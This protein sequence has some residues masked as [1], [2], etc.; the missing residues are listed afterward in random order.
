MKPASTDEVARV[1]QLLS[2]ER[3]AMVPQGGNTSLC[4]GSVP[5]ASGAQVV[6]N[7]SRMNRVRA[8][9]TDN[10][11]MTVEAGCVLASLQ[12][13]AD[14]HGR[15]FPLSLGAEGSCEIGGN[16]STNA[17][18]TGVLRYGNTRELVLGLEVVLADGQVWNGLRGTAQGQH[19][20][21]PEASLRRRRGHARHHHRGGAEALPEAA[22]A[23]DRLRRDRQPRP[24]GRAAWA[25]SANRCGERV[26][27]YELLGRICV[28]LIGKHMPAT[29]D[30]F[31]EPHPWYVLVELSDS[32][33]GDAARTMLEEALAE[34]HRGRA[35]ARRR[36]VHEPSAARGAL[37]DARGH[38][39]G[40]EAGRPLGEARRVGAREPRARA[41]RARRRGA[42]R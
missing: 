2:A 36:G 29:R 41:D 22:L 4:G 23:G 10:N 33:E 9:D 34:R 6:I 27:G 14:R 35:R 25:A 3:V 7:L 12:A 19:R 30:P 40:A 17:G 39:R 31:P 42:R 1:V 28:E 21:R 8:V 5:D 18:G 11:T 32:T 37:A 20:L 38:H 16:L 26:T 24:G 15:L 13:E